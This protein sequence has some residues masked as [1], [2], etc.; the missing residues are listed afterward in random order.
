MKLLDA[1][2][3]RLPGLEAADESRGSKTAQDQAV[4]LALQLR[5]LSEP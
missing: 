5:A 2:A 3:R 4:A 1:Q